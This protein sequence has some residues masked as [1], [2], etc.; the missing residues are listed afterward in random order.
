MA[1]V[2]RPVFACRCCC[3]SYLGLGWSG[4]PFRL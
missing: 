2:V 1:T 3:R 4:P